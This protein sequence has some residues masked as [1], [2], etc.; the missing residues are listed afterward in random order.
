MII[1]SVVLF[2]PTRVEAH[3]AIKG[4]GEFVSGLLHPLLTPL[5]LMVLLSLGLLLGQRL[6]LR[7]KWPVA[8]FAGFA[9]A[10][11]VVT[12]V[13][14][15]SGVYPP[16]LILIG[17]CSGGFV[18]LAAPLSAWVS[19][20]VCAAAGLALGL[21]SGVDSATAGTAM[22]KTL[23]ATWVCLTL[24]VANVAFYSSYLPKHQWVQTGIRVVGS[25]IVA[26]ALL[27]L[28]FSLKR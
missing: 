3:A 8:G 7:L 11:L 18:A 28:A 27:M 5:H 15:G 21:D 24:C 10:G 16:V 20:A 2:L 25:W 13:S 14:A 22:A 9:A 19:L 4:A 6:P 26:I 17:L 12:T 23:F 1:G